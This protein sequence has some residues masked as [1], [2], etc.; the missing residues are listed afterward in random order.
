MPKLDRRSFLAHAGLATLCAPWLSLLGSQGARAGAQPP[1]QAKYL[2]LFHTTGTDLSRWTPVGSTP[3]NLVPS[4]MLAPLDAIRS[5]VV[6]I[7]RLD[8]RGTAS[9]HSGPGGLT[10]AGRRQNTKSIDQ[11]VADELRALGVRTSI[12]SLVLGSVPGQASHTFYNDSPLTPI[13]DPVAAYETIFGGAAGGAGGGDGSAAEDLLRRRRS[14]LD[15]VRGE[16]GELSAA[17]GA[18]ERRKLEL[19]LD[20]LRQLEDRLVREA[21][22]GEAGGGTGGRGDACGTFASPIDAGQPLG[23]AALH[24]DLAISAFSCD[25]TRVAAVEFGHHQATPVSMP[26]IGDGDWH[27]GF[28]HGGGH[29]VDE[30]IALE[31][32]LTQ[33][34]VD[35]AERLKSLPAPDGDGTLFDQTLL[36]W[37]R[38]MGDGVVHAGTNMPF[39]FTGGAGGA[40]RT[41]PGGRYLDGGGH[42]HARALV[43]IAEM[44]GVADHRQFGE[45]DD[46]VTGDDKAPLAEL[47]S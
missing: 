17:L 24:L 4:E 16:L 7:D 10:G 33:R 13:H 21:G 26:E 18:D 14:A 23:N 41:A 32:W 47:W 12:P 3:T 25:L 39:V 19:H 28:L 15:L 27:S 43:S 45:P 9:N 20:S 22:G 37:T 8:S 11:H 46:E 38:G 42:Y 2:L 30:L 6:V 36:V 29:R 44:M 40:L 1:G 35:A 31:R 5:E 34:F